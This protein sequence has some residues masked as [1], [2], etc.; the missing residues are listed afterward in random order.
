MQF[1]VDFFQVPVLS[2]LVLEPFEVADDDAP[3]VG[4]YIGKEM[5]TSLAENGVAARGSRA[6]GAF[7]DEVHV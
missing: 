4:E 5:N 1:G 6:I 7:G 3:S 2:S